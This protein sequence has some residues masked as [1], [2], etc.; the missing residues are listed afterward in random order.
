MYKRDFLK[1][2]SKVIACATLAP[3]ALSGDPKGAWSF[4]STAIG[5]TTKGTSKV[6]TTAPDLA[7]LLAADGRLGSHSRAN[8]RKEDAVARPTR[9]LPIHRKYMRFSS[10]GIS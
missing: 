9:V 5:A 8:H 6:R 7:C 1:T 3:D 2:K 4:R 10:A